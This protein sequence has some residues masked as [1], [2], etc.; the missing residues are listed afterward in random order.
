MQTSVWSVKGTNGTGINI[1]A[2]TADKTANNEIS[3]ID[4]I[5]MARMI[6]QKIIYVNCFIYSH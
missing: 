5:F 1:L 2:P 3:A 4:F 6:S